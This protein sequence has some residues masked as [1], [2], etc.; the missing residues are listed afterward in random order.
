MLCLSIDECMYLQLSDRHRP[1]PCTPGLRWVEQNYQ[2]FCACDM[3]HDDGSWKKN[4][5]WLPN[6]LHCSAPT[7]QRT[8][9]DVVIFHSSISVCTALLAVRICNLRI[10]PTHSPYHPPY[11]SI[12]SPRTSHCPCMWMWWSQK[13]LCI[14]GPIQKPSSQLVRKRLVRAEERYRDTYHLA[15]YVVRRVGHDVA[16][17]SAWTLSSNSQDLV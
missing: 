6:S 12:I 13:W 14:P 16:L 2:D 7:G 1:V 17:V 10:V 9:M 8:M 15:L 4:K 11:C 3:F 5:R